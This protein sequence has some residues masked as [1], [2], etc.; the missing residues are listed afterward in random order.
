M[1]ARALPLLALAKPKGPRGKE[2]RARGEAHRRLT[3]LEADPSPASLQVK[4]SPSC[5]PDRSPPG[6]RARDPGKPRAGA[7]GVQTD[8][9]H[10]GFSH[11]D[12][13]GLCGG[14]GCHTRGHRKH[15]PVY[16]TARHACAPTL[17]SLPALCPRASLP[18][19]AAGA[20]ALGRV[21]APC[22]RV[23][24][25]GK[26]ERLTTSP[27]GLAGTTEPC[28]P[29]LQPPGVRWDLPRPRWARDSA[30]ACAKLSEG[31]GWSPAFQSRAP[32]ET[33]LPL[34]ARPLGAE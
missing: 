18:R 7:R 9:T 4:P 12:S 23:W 14:R 5:R 26:W 15:L 29:A 8:G 28:A 22:R 2:Q 11:Q 24:P 33:R 17:S 3:A 27:D 1:L 19:G 34:L 16:E 10:R 20:P 30:A 6:D 32:A 31:S 13:G 25:G 21:T